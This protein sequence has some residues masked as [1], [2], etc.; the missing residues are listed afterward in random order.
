MHRTRLVT[1]MLGVVLSAVTLTACGEENGGTG[2]KSSSALV[3][4]QRVADSTG[5]QQSAKVEG[6]ITQGTPQGEQHTTMNGAM[7]WSQGYVLAE[8]SIVQSGG[9][10]SNSPID[11][12]PMPTRYLAD[13]YYV[14]MGDEF[15]ATAGE[16]AHWIKY[17][18]DRLA[19]QLGPAGAFV[20]DQMQNNNPSRSVELLL[21]TGEVT[22]VGTETVHGQ[23]TTHYRGSFEVADLAD[24][25]SQ[26]MSEQQLRDLRDQ[27]EASGM[28]TETIDLWVNADDLLVKKVESAESSQGASYES[29]VYYSD[30]GT[31]VT[32]DAPDA[33]DSIDFD[34]VTG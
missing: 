20:K 30:Y 27:L 16:G 31:S 1:V 32:V 4:L 15:A 5:E 2:G 14:N 17:D 6:S 10:V 7:D 22:E 11:G 26:E 18:Y 8:V 19:E 25:Q 23:S 33:A 12:M 29:T 21:A 3:V 13:A 9:L 24:M 34:Q 28:E